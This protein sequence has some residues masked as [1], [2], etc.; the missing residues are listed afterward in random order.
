M[1][2]DTSY[3]KISIVTPP[4]NQWEFLEREILREAGITENYVIICGSGEVYREFLY[5]DNL[6]DACIFLMERF[7]YKDIGEI[8]NIGTGEDMKLKDLALFIKNVVGFEGEIKYDL[9]KPDGTPRKLLD[10][11]CVSILDII[12]I[13]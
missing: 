8:I 6:V 4:Y 1:K 9:S 12:I 2:R 13:F 10:V 5:V 11:Y 3:P 7:N